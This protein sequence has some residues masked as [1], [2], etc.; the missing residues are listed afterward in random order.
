MS[1]LSPCLSLSASCHFPCCQLCSAGGS[2]Q[3]VYD[4]CRALRGCPGGSALAGPR[5][6]VHREQ[7]LRA[8]NISSPIYFYP[9]ERTHAAEVLGDSFAITVY[10]SE[11]VRPGALIAITLLCT[12]TAHIAL[13][14][15][16]VWRR[17][18][19][20]RLRLFWPARPRLVVHVWCLTT[21]ECVC[22]MRRAHTRGVA[23][24][25]GFCFGRPA[26]ACAP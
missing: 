22:V 5:M 9:P 12:R 8:H 2:S 15:L 24:T 19:A 1:R 25:L 17:T 10:W 18:S 4:G 16:C 26:H 21:G 23:C 20:Q 6:H 11:R 14:R 7:W 3:G 13:V